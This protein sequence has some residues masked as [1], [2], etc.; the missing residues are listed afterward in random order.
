[1]KIIRKALLPILGLAVVGAIIYAFL[2]RPVE[3]D[4]ASVRR[5]P[6]RVTVDED[7]KTRIKE[8]YVVSSPLAGQLLR[9]RL[10]PGDVVVPGKTVL[11]A[12]APT[13]PALL[14][15]RAEV[16]ARARVKAA[17]A[18]LHQA[19]ANLKRAEAAHDLAR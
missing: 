3:V 4:L 8:R 7:G 14:D 18:G 12:I 1:M 16:Q 11:A 6:L 2:P 19:E 15:P 17:R 5:G 10:K 9:I 13:D